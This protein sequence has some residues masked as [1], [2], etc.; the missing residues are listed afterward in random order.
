M[1]ETPWLKKN[2]IFI[3]AGA[4]FV[5]LAW[6]LGVAV[7]GKEDSAGPPPSFWPGQVAPPAR[8]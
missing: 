5:F 8:K 6:R 3:A 4:I 2:W 7:F 1:Q